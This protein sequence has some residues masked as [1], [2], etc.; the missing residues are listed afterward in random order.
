MREIKQLVLDWLLMCVVVS[1]ILTA[2]VGLSKIYGD[3][4]HNAEYWRAKVAT[5][6]A[7]Q[8]NENSTTTLAPKPPEAVANLPE[9]TM[10]SIPGCVPCVRAETDDKDGKFKGLFTLKKWDVTI[11]EAPIPA[12]L[13]PVFYWRG[14]DGQMWRYPPENPP[15]N[16][17]HY[18]GHAELI[19][20]W[21]QTQA[22][23]KTQP[24]A[25]S[26]PQ[27]FTPEQQTLIQQARQAGYTDQQIMQYARKRGYIR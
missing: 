12:D 3:D 20:I 16:T 22:K 11:R 10:F 19:R 17:A 21:K 1:V 7:I 4:A 23:P 5:A 8:G 14:A 18:P 26:P 2:A 6:I 24:V 25:R 9:M 13:F 27:Q 15:E